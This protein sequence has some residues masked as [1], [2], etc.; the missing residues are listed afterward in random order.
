MKEPWFRKINVNGRTP[1]IQDENPGVTLWES[2]A[3]IEY[4]LDTYDH[5]RLISFEKSPLGWQVSQW[6]HF[7]MSGQGPYFGQAAWFCHFHTEKVIS[8][9]IRYKE[10]I[11]RV[12]T[13]LN[14]HLDGKQY[15]V[16]EKWSVHN[17]SEIDL[18]LLE[19]TWVFE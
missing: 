18:S 4:L 12:Y 6:I 16:G 2:G 8:A 11:H 1:A 5:Q 14:N 15:L 13:T 17:P 19:L 9:Q 7:Q 3:I 10:Q